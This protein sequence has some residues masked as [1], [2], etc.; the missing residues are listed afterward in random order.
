MS[1]P[2]SYTGCH[3]SEIKL[4]GEVFASCMPECLARRIVALLNAAEGL[5]MDQ[6]ETIIPKIQRDPVEQAS[7]LIRVAAMIDA[8]K[9]PPHA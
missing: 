4:R 2:Y 3:P 8:A 6:I 5:G 9:E 1:Q 7:A